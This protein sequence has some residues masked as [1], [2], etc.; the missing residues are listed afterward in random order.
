MRRA[1][2]PLPAGFASIAGFLISAALAVWLWR[3]DSA[4]APS[5]L[6]RLWLLLFAVPP[7]LALLPGRLRLCLAFP[8]AGVVLV[9]GS[10]AG[11]AL[12]LILALYLAALPA[13]IF[14][15]RPLRM[16][17]VI[18]LAVLLAAAGTALLFRLVLLDGVEP[19]LSPP[20]RESGR[21]LR[22]F[23]LLSC[24]ADSAW[25]FLGLA[26]LRFHDWGLARRRVTRSSG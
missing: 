17:R 7:M 8:A 22:G 24:L 21:A 1:C 19:F 16:E 13:A 15:L 23:L 11:L 18:A 14:R 26:V 10:P 9:L 5:W 3:S 12:P 20:V 25:I 2:D 4:A 6:W